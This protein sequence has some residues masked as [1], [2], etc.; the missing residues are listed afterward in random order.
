MLDAGS[1][2]AQNKSNNVSM[3]ANSAVTT[4]RKLSGNTAVEVDS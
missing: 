2:D 3:G 1:F 4:E